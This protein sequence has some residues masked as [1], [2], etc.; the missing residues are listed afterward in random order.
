MSLIY[1]LF[2]N[3]DNSRPA[4]PNF[5]FF[6]D[7][8]NVKGHKLGVSENGSPIFFIKCDN[9][10]LTKYPSYNLGIDV[11]FG[12]DCKI[13]DGKKKIRG[14]YTLITLKENSEY[15]LP[16]FL[17]IVLIVVQSI[18]SNASLQ[19][20]K[21]E[22]DKLVE[23][24]S[25]ILGKGTGDIQGLWAELLIIE[26]SKNPDY[27]ISSWHV[28]KTALFDFN[29][30]EDKLEI[31]STSKNERKHTFSLHQLIPNK[32]SN[33][34]VG[35]ILVTITG[36]GKNVFDL[37]SSI[38]NRVQDKNVVIKLGR[39]VSETLGDKI[40]TAHSV[41]FDYNSAKD[42]IAFFDYNDIPKL[43]SKGI[44]S[45]ITNVHFDCNL[46]QI[47]HAVLKKY[48]SKLYKVL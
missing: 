36:Q 27:L 10:D 15:L 18:P 25:N 34:I 48:K 35:S 3:L 33:L 22:I 11:D 6:V 44:P 20:V 29:N 24:F 13:T 1:T 28:L 2:Q 16:Y 40:H 32:S 4:D 21:Y 43:D 37:I 38:E 23:M 7:I 31:K 9:N 42:S 17:D 5:Y 46:S 47:K 26:Q 19:V 8:P 12:E 41:Y 45:E 39:I 14:K 30:G